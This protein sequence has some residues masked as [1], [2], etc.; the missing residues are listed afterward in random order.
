MIARACQCFINEKCFAGIG[1][2]FEALQQIALP[3]ELE[4]GLPLH[5]RFSR[6][7]VQDLY[8]PQ[9]CGVMGEQWQGARWGIWQ[10]M[11]SPF[12][13]F[14]S[15]S[16]V[17]LVR[18][19]EL[20][21]MFSS[22]GEWIQGKGPL[23][24]Y[25]YTLDSETRWKCAEWS[26][27]LHQ[28]KMD[29]EGQKDLWCEIFLAES[30]RFRKAAGVKREEVLPM[31]NIP[32]DGGT[33]GCA[34]KLHLKMQGRFDIFA[35]KTLSL[36]D[37]LNFRR[38]MVGSPWIS[39]RSLGMKV[40]ALPSITYDSRCGILDFKIAS[41][42]GGR[43]A[44]RI[45]CDKAHEKN[46]EVFVWYPGFHLANHSNYLS[47]HPEWI[48]RKADGSPFT[49][50]YFHI[51]AISAR[52]EA[53]RHFINLLKRLKKDCH[54]DGL[55]L[56]S[57]NSMPFMSLDFSRKQGVA[58]TADAIAMVKRLQDIG[59]KIINE[60][61]SPFGARGD[62]ESMFFLGQEEM[63]VETSL[64]TYYKNNPAILKD[65]AYFRFLANKAPLTVAAKYLPK[66]KMK[67]I[68]EWNRAFNQA[69][70]HM[71]HRHLLK[72]KRGVIWRD[73]KGVEILFAYRNFQHKL[74]QRASV[75]D[76]IS[77]KLIKCKKSMGAKKMKIYK[78]DADL[79]LE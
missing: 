28:E 66:G 12:D 45:F 60:G 14:T 39:Y 58:N 71:I 21:G 11:R 19:G 9:K 8:T 59:L 73:E 47:K 69:V 52:I 48:I 29:L 3:L 67:K 22:G 49:W 65:H 40:K 79:A 70:K 74:L 53:Q 78:I 36:C 1:L 54:F 75:I 31:A 35:E 50:V 7:H 33:P 10:G 13:L 25:R 76:L 62:G 17:L 72:N 64:F 61:Y 30:E 46:M 26:L 38:I 56:D 55:W 20:A 6:H 43:E 5:K 63:A 44:F 57:Y 34:P 42:Y 4:I 23:F 24:R 77:D 37:K 18:L 2:R 15:E 41:Q 16:N 27:L 32:I 51:T 68:G